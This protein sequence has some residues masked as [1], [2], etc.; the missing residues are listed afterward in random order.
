MI[1]GL[2]ARK[3]PGLV[4][5][6]SIAETTISGVVSAVVASLSLGI[7]SNGAAVA[8][9][10]SMSVSMTVVSTVVASLTLSISGY[11]ATVAVAVS[12]SVS[13]TIESSIVTVYAGVDLLI[14]YFSHFG[15][16]GDGRS[17]QNSQNDLIISSIDLAI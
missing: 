8:V 10:V 9:A 4:V 3:W 16:L 2:T 11:G 17:Q 5:V 15:L 13:M 1:E 6:I 7:S 14:G 12:I